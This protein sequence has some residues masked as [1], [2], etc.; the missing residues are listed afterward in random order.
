MLMVA[1]VMLDPSHAAL[2]SQASALQVP[3]ASLVR[4]PP[5]GAGPA[6]VMTKCSSEVLRSVPFT[7]ASFSSVSSLKPAAAPRWVPCSRK[8]QGREGQRLRARTVS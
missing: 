5:S 8:V 7:S 3:K 6:C 4:P 2:P 1:A